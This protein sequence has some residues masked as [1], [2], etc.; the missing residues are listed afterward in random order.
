MKIFSEENVPVCVD[1]DAH[2]P[3]RVGQHFDEAYKLLKDAGFKE[4]AVF[5]NRER[6]LVPAGF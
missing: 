1:S 4:M 5:S 3:D 2:F 6:F